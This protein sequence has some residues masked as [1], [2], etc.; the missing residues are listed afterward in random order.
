MT[1][2]KCDFCGKQVDKPEKLRQIH[3]Q[4]CISPER[5]KKL[6]I[7]DDCTRELNWFLAVMMARKEV[8][9]K[10]KESE[11]T[12]QQE[13]AK[14][15]QEKDGEPFYVYGPPECQKVTRSKNIGRYG[16]KLTRA[17]I[18]KGRYGQAESEY[19]HAFMCG[20][21]PYG[22]DPTRPTK[23]EWMAQEPYDFEV[24]LYLS[25]KLFS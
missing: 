8:E 2:Y 15:A 4:I 19:A 13:V 20:G 7:C 25:E 1:I 16:R 18:Y 22:K 10:P 21:F 5:N 9:D 17:D 3:Q 24:D 23:E 11:P 12:S 14:S 6:D